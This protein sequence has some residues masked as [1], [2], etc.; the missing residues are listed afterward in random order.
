MYTNFSAKKIAIFG[1][2]VSGL[3]A[4]RFC[5]LVKADAVVVGSGN[6]DSWDFKDQK[7][8][9]CLDQNDAN[10]A[11]ILATL[12]LIILSPGIP[13]EHKVLKEALEK[14]IPV[15]NEVEIAAEYFPG[16]II[17][18]TG[19][20]GKTTTVS[21]MAQVLRQMGQ[22]VFL[23][24]NYGV[25]F[26]DWVCDFLEKKDVPI[27]FAVIELSSFQLE[28]LFHFRCHFGAILNITP[29][30]SERYPDFEN[31]KKAKLRLAQLSS[32]IFHSGQLSEGF[33]LPEKI[34]R[35]AYLNSMSDLSKFPLLGDYNRDNLWFVF[36]MLQYFHLDPKKVDLSALKGEAYRL[37]RI[38]PN[39]YNDA[40][41]T[42]WQAT[43]SAVN[44]LK[45]NKDLCLIL[46]GKKRG[47]GDGPTKEQIEYLKKFVQQFYLYGESA[48]DLSDIFSG[49]VYDSISDVITNI[50]L[51][52]TILFSPAYP[53]FDQ[54]RDYKER[55]KTFSD[56]I[57]SQLS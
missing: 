14:E 32:T 9:P 44:A 27:D 48:G 56:L 2:G 41:S 55:G 46:G 3:A 57:A 22:S 5:H 20:N 21:L 24:G 36:Q 23:G 40:K 53:S 37:E 7:R 26:L 31:Y 39:I 29:S 51:E 11:R 47:E 28:S 6:A 38:A 8:V 43:V 35:E 10:T 4:L 1:L 45:D 16:K 42:N 52:H 34:E 15:V 33:Y 13:R 54:F 50:N 18:V 25:P 30:H 12:D 17:A 19:T 49:S